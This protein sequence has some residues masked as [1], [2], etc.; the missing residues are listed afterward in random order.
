MSN[1]AASNYPAIDKALD[2]IRTTRNRQNI[3][4]TRDKVCDSMSMTRSNNI[5][6]MEEIVCTSESTA[7]VISTPLPGLPS[8][9][10]GM[11]EGLANK[12]RLLALKDFEQMN[13]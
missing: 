12:A 5:T 7:N 1:S 6:L 4:H 11:F 13:K 3:T 9:Q 2:V 10:S 8:Q